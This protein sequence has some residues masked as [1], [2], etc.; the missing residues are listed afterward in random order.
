MGEGPVL[1]AARDFLRLRVNRDQSAA[2]ERPD[3]RAALLIESEIPT[4]Q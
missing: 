2:W 3:V 1:A 4:G